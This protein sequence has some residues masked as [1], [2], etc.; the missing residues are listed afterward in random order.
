MTDVVKPLA[1]TLDACDLV[2]AADVV[3][4]SLSNLRFGNDERKNPDFE[5]F[6]QSTTLIG[7]T[8]EEAQAAA[9]AAVIAMSPTAAVLSSSGSL[10]CMSGTDDKDGSLAEA[11]HSN[12]AGTEQQSYT[13]DSSNAATEA[14]NTSEH[15]VTPKD[16]ELLK[17]IG[18][19]AFGKVL[20]VRNKQSAQ[21]LAMKIISKRQLRKK[22]GYIENIQAE[23]NILKRV[24]HPF[25]VKMHCSFQTREKLFIIMDFL[26]GGELFLR[27]GREGIFMERD[28]AFYL[29]E[30][31]SGVDHLH[32]L[33]ILHRDLKPEN[34]LLCND[35]HICLTDFGLAKDFG[36]G[37]SDRDGSE[38]QERAR[39]IC[40]TQEYMAPEMVAN[41]GY[42]KAADYWSLGC[43]AYEMLNGLPPFS[44]K[45][46]SKELFR[47]IMSEKVKMPPGST[48]EACKLLKGLLNRNPDKRLG[49]AR[50]T[51]FEVGG[52]AGLKQ[53]PFF[54]K[55][56]WIKLDLKQLKPPYDLNVDN[57]SDLR[58]FHNEFTEMPLPRSV[59][60]MSKEDH[61]PRRIASDTFRGFS[62]IQDDFALPSRDAKEIENY[63][64]TV[65]EDGESDSDL[66]SSK[67]GSD[68]E[69]APTPQPEKKKRPPRKRKKK[70]KNADLAASETAS[71]VSADTATT[72]MPSDTEG[73]TASVPSEAKAPQQES[74]SNDPPKQAVA[75]PLPQPKSSGIT[76][77][78]SSKPLATKT[79]MPPPKPV[80]KDAWTSVGT[81]GAK[82]RNRVAGYSPTTSK[83]SFNTTQSRPQSL[84]A[85]GIAASARP[86]L[87]PS[88]RIPAPTGKA[89]PPGSWAARLHQASTATSSATSQQARP[90]N[91][92]TS[93]PPPP[94][95]PSSDWRTHSSPQIRRAIKRGSLQ[96]A[97][98]STNGTTGLGRSGPG[99]GTNTWPSLNDFPAAPSLNPA[100]P[101]PKPN[102]PVAGAWA[103]RTHR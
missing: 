71:V 50:S 4:S 35:G 62:F 23:R 31:I 75:P 70:K 74:A 82:S 32:N 78:A 17:V 39:T 46:G 43:I 56:D 9:A 6:N 79:E 76:I 53:Q 30:T 20:Q 93:A 36:T 19:G 15:F 88:G 5:D 77:A 16:F 57:E 64:K 28:A 72:P 48:A 37:W 44:S 10:Q 34:I 42:G 84:N 87:V 63:W 29:A 41:K 1:E 47:K 21:I 102:R 12:A 26:A 3:D 55:I 58:N 40:G 24:N 89:P 59:K 97:A 92:T 61:K 94:P 68:T 95:S 67:F 85:P 13:G 73:E 91:P 27:L 22:S 8:V 25:V 99:S 14:N 69:Q 98:A 49:S 100:K 66:A 90:G 33:G 101:T 54:A 51:M 81:S 65:E 2:D 38:D 11:V 103:S 18:M 52:V 7:E 60:E 96:S 86:G 83:S 80:V 45:Q